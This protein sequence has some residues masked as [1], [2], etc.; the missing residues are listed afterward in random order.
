VVPCVFA[1]II[2]RTAFLLADFSLVGPNILV[3]HSELLIV[4]ETTFPKHAGSNPR[5][6]N[7]RGKLENEEV[8]RKIRT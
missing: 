2:K 8:K 4:I 3:P 6:T 7:G 5:A 1:N